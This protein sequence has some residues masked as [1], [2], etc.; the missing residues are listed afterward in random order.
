MHEDGSSSWTRLKWR[1]LS[2]YKSFRGLER[3]VLWCA[4]HVPQTSNDF[5]IMRVMIFSALISESNFVPVTY[6]MCT[7]A[8]LRFRSK[9][10]QSSTGTKGMRDKLCAD[11]PTFLLRRNLRSCETSWCRNSWCSISPFVSY[12]NK[13]WRAS[14]IFQSFS[15][16]LC[17]KCPL[18]TAHKFVILVYS[19][20]PSSHPTDETLLGTNPNPQ[21]V[22]P[23]A[24]LCPT[25]RCR[26][27]RGACR[28]RRD[29]PNADERTQSRPLHRKGLVCMPP[30]YYVCSCGP[31]SR[32]GIYFR[33]WGRR[34]AM[35]GLSSLGF[36]WLELHL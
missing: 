26:G 31:S 24:R 13:S 19:K 36:W 16:I 25:I 4:L 21:R 11:L 1:V 18:C 28:Q 9:M 34:R 14:Y 5:Q 22:S 8:P 23:L 35:R 6:A 20:R 33:R 12:V 32:Q 27:R 17:S 2:G 29:I 7:N 3:G 15:T 10:D 30:V